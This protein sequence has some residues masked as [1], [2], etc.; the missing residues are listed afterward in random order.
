MEGKI[1]GLA[2]S[3]DAM[4]SQRT[5]RGAM[6]LEEAVEEVKKCAGTQFDPMLVDIFLS[7]DPQTLTNELCALSAQPL[8][9]S[10]PTK[11]SGIVGAEKPTGEKLIL[12]G[13]PHVTTPPQAV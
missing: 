10:P 12:S 5:Y 2:D 1:I 7:W 3:W 9:S 6:S 13:L 11:P 4:T 8:Y